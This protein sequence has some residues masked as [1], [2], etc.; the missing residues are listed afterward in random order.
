MILNL[1]R[2]GS[3]EVRLTKK[4][5]KRLTESIEARMLEGDGSMDLKDIVQTIYTEVQARFN[6]NQRVRAAKK[7]NE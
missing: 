1:I 4:T 6:K 3:K 5:I 7:K 2:I